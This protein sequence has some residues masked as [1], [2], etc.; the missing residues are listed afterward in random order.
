MLAPTAS[1]GSSVLATHLRFVMQL[2]FVG[3]IVLCSIAVT[4]LVMQVM[5][6]RSTGLLVRVMNRIAAGDFSAR[7]QLAT[8]MLGARRLA[9]AVNAMAVAL[10]SNH[11]QRQMSEERFRCIAETIS[12]VFWIADIGITNTLYVS[13]AY[14]RIWGRSCDSLY[15]DPRSFLMGIHPEDFERV[16]QELKV[17]ET[18]QPFELEYRIIRPD[19]A[20]RWI[21]DRGFPVPN[22][23]GAVTRYLGIAQD[24]SARENLR[25][26]HGEVE[27][28]LRFAL[29][30]AHVGI[31]ESDLVTGVSFW[32]G[33]C[34]VMHG[35]APGTFGKSFDAFFE[36]IDADDRAR[37]SQQIQQAM[38]DRREVEIEYLTTWPDGSRHWIVATAH[39]FYDERGVPVRG[40]GVTH[41]VTERRSLEEQL[42]QAQDV[43]ARRPPRLGA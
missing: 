35:L 7:A 17:Q 24:I 4:L 16:T 38:R 6:V 25:R 22:E 32:S 21:W 29:E 41:D 11:Q 27:E 34:E 19:G 20:V 42:R 33:T 13:P 31:W 39:F 10:E 14:E 23:E 30:A 8:G 37:V 40:A 36:R 2:W 26:A 3:L 18:G 28:R 12:E 9:D 5:T 1:L 43:A 15:K